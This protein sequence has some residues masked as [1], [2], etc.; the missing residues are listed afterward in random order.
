MKRGVNRPTNAS[1]AA[2][3]VDC[4]LGKLKRAAIELI[5]QDFRDLFSHL[6]GASI[7]HI[8][9]NLNADAHKL[10]GLREALVTN[11]GQNN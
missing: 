10:V 5:V 1:D 7:Q 8:R 4:I 11:L 2:M 9:R 3:V 6:K